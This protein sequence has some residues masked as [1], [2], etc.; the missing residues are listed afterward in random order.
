MSRKLDGNCTEN[1]KESSIWNIRKK[2]GK[3]LRARKKDP[4][5]DGE[6]ESDSA[7]QDET[8][9]KQNKYIKISQYKYYVN[10][11]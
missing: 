7:K 9:R 1:R 11:Y 8:T 2:V 10:K 6:K 5:S 3:I 4:D